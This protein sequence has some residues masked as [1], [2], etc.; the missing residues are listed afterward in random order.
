M[1]GDQVDY[2]QHLRFGWVVPIAAEKLNEVLTCSIETSGV[3]LRVDDFL[4]KLEELHLLYLC[5]EFEQWI[6]ANAI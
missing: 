3:S 6:L 4:L 2:L 5:F 1:F